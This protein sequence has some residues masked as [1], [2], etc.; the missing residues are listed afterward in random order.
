[1][2]IYE[3]ITKSMYSM[4]SDL[5]ESTYSPIINTFKDFLTEMINYFPKIVSFN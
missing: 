3:L 5:L 2:Y 4:H 1:M